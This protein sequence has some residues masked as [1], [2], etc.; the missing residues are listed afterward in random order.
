[1]TTTSPASRRRPAEGAR[2]DH[3]WLHFTRMGGYAD[4]EVP[5]IVR[6]EGCY[7]EDSNGKRYLDAL[8][9]PVR[10][11][12]SATRTARRSA[13]A[14]LE[15]MREL[16]FYTNWSYAHPRAIELAAEVASLAPGDLTASSSS[17]AARRPSS[18]PGSSRGSTTRARRA[19]GH[20]GR[21]PDGRRRAAYAGRRRARRAPRGRAALEGGLAQRRLPRHDDGRALD[22]RHPRAADAVRAARPGGRCT[23][24]T[25]TATTARRRRPRRS[26]RAFL[27]DD[28]EHDDRRGGA[29]DGCDGDHGAGP[30]RGRR[31][32][33]PAGYWQGVREL[34]DRYGILLCADEVITGFGRLGALVR[35]RALRHP[36]RHRHLREG[37]LLGLRRR[38][39]RCSTTDR[40]MEPFL[41][42]RRDVHA[43]DHVR[44]PPGAWRRSRSRTSRS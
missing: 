14:A 38:S 5:V 31:L 17:R 24:A 35:L 33:A 29:R 4:T 25:R 34:C 9:G 6:G 28:L 37:P 10:G 8:A 18:R 42:G 7:L 36:A 15:Q 12:T 44:R 22:Q 32:H 3:L 30:E 11:A 39:A 13:Q 41:D 40:V 23:S 1:M 2:R 21:R 19:P 26:S 43:R 27:L 20:H 16:P